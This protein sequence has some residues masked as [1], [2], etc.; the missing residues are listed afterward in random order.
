MS[1]T[2]KLKKEPKP[3][4]V[5]SGYDEKSPITGNYSVMVEKI[6]ND[7]YPPESNLPA[8]DI[9]K[10]CMETGYQTYWETWKVENTDLINQ[11]EA[12]M[13]SWVRNFKYIDSYNRVWYPMLAISHVATLHPYPDTE[14]QLGWTVSTLSLI[15]EEKDL[16]GKQIIKLPV[17]TAD[18]VKLALYKVNTEESKYWKFNEF[19]PAFD[20]YQSIVS[21]SLNSINETSDEQ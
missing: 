1:K 5:K 17:E 8:T 6:T 16:E 12:T 4:K 15:T 21:E 19:E 3:E 14:S 7:D 20:Y 13:P 2:I 9:Y 11:I 10:I 18:G